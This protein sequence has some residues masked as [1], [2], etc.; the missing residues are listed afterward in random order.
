MQERHTPNADDNFMVAGITAWKVS[1]FGVFPVRM[2]ENTDQKN[3]EYGHFIECFE[4]FT[5]PNAW[6]FN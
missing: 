4:Q 3:S 2:L 6:A 5:E 1:V